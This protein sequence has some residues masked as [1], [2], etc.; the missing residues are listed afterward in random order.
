[1]NHPFV[2]GNMRVAVFVT[3]AFLRMNGQRLDLEVQAAF[4]YVTALFDAQPFRRDELRPWLAAH[5][6]PAE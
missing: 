3:Y 1:M 4:A 6:H 5:A 2:D